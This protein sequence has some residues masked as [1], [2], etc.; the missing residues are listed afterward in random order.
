M[1]IA[2]SK[3]QLS[4]LKYSNNIGVAVKFND[5]EDY[6]WIRIHSLKINH[7]NGTKYSLRF[8]NDER[9]WSMIIDST[10]KEYVFEI[11]NSYS[12]WPNEDG[13]DY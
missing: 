6:L 11:G 2:K 9:S 13:K 1:N 5:S 8:S 7:K 4:I 10:D 3:D 12:S